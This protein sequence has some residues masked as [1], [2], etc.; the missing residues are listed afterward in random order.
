MRSL[1]NEK[2]VTKETPP[3]FLFHT[4][5]DTAVPAENS[6]QFY[7]ALR[8]AGVPAELHI[9]RKGAHGLG[10]AAKVPGTSAWPGCCEAW[11]RN[12]GFLAK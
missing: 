12:Q 5:E 8:R 10:L 1:S 11:M 3:T 9:F 6:V 4:D 2:Q 7:L